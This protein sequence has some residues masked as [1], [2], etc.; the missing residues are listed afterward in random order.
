MSTEQRVPVRVCTMLR[1]EGRSV[2]FVVLSI[3]LD[4]QRVVRAPWGGVIHSAH[5]CVLPCL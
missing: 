5:C 2:R 1:A 4:P 3:I